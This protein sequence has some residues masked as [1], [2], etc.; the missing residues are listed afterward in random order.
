MKN[1]SSEEKLLDDVFDD[2]LTES[3]TTVRRLARQRRW[4]RHARKVVVSGFLIGMT[5]LWMREAHRVAPRHDLAAQ[6]A[7]QHVGPAALTADQIVRTTARGYVTV[8]TIAT[9]ANIVH[10]EPHAIALDLLTDEDL[11]LIA[12]GALLVYH[13]STSELLLPQDAKISSPLPPSE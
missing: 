3:L 6:S 9:P 2:P 1:R 12:P 13:G 5:C 4:N 8:N 10:T 11:L 7:A